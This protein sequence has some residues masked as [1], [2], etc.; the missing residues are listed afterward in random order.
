MTLGRASGVLAVLF[1]DLVG[2]TEL[3]VR[4]GDAAFDELRGE[5]F[6]RLREV[7]AAGRSSPPPSSGPWRVL[8]PRPASPTSG[9]WS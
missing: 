4:L 8:G 7:V 9:R 3:M 2:S 5:H 6:A 1:T